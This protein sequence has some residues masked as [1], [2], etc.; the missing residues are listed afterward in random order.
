MML[1]VIQ[2]VG[3]VQFYCEGLGIPS[4]GLLGLLGNVAAIIVLRLV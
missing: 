3:Q 1:I 4:V 2:V